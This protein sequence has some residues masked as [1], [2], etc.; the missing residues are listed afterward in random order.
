[1]GGG[2]SYQKIEKQEDFVTENFQ[3]EKTRMS[4]HSYQGNN[5]YSDYQIKMKMRQDYNS[6]GKKL[7]SYRMDKNSYIPSSHWH[8]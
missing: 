8:N 3:R 1:M 4:K 6:G 2:S 7:S 5:M